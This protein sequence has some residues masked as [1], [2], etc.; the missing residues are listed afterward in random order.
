MLF[1]AYG[2]PPVSRRTDSRG[3][4]AHVWEA[5]QC[6]MEK[7]RPCENL[8]GLIVFYTQTNRMSTWT[9]HVLTKVKKHGKRQVCRGEKAC[10]RP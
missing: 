5:Y 1:T 4:G 2:T 3:V 7:T 8:H 6:A 10:E 9:G